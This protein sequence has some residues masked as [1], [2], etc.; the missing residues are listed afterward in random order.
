MDTKKRRGHIEEWM[1]DPL[2]IGSYASPHNIL[3]NLKAI[4]RLESERIL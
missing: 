3:E 2:N 4:K 1:S